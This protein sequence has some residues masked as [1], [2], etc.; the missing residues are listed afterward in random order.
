MF[1]TRRSVFFGVCFGG[2][3]GFAYALSTMLVNWLFLPN[4]PLKPVQTDSAASYFMLYLAIG[5]V[6]GFITGL[7]SS[8]LLGVFLGGFCSALVIAII[9]LFQP[10]TQEETIY[11][12][13]FI[14]AYTFLPMGV[15]LMPAAGLIRLGINAQNP[16]PDHPELWARRYLVPALVTLG[17]I[18]IGSFSLFDANTREGFRVV[19]NMILA[20]QTAQSA[21]DLPAPLQA[22]QGY[23]ELGRGD[24]QLAYSDDLENFMGPQPV[25]DQLLVFLVVA[26]FDSGLR[27]ACVFL[28]GETRVPTCTNF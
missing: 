18:T 17:V 4:I 13:F 12:A 1:S 28:G 3:L 5:A 23:W 15:I 16:D 14:F 26:E 19:N 21:V 9:S 7:P 24:Y 27:F 10:S 25:G 2:F 11:R 22:V 8:G 20:S 6:L